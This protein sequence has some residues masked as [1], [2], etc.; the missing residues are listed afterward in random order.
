[1]KTKYILSFISVFILATLLYALSQGGHIL[2]WQETSVADFFDNERHNLIIKN[3]S[4]GEVR[5]PDPI[6]KTANDHINNSIPRGTAYD[7]DGNYLRVWVVWDNIFAQK[8]T[9]SG[10]TLSPKIRVNDKQISNAFD[11][12][13]RSALLDNG[14]F[15]V[16]WTDQGSNDNTMYGQAFSALTIKGSANFIINEVENGSN[17]IPAVWAN[18]N[19]GNFWILYSRQYNG[20]YKILV[21]KR[22]IQGSQI[23]S[24]FVLNPDNPTNYEAEVS[25]TSGENGSFVVAWGGNNENTSTAADV[26]IRKF[27]AAG[28]PLTQAV[29]AIREGKSSYQGHPSVCKDDDGNYLAAWTD[30][31][32]NHST[33]S[34]SFNIYGQFFNPELKKLGI[35]FRI[36]TKKYSW[37]SEPDIRFRDD[38]FETSG[39]WRNDF[40]HSR[41][42]P[43]RSGICRNCLGRCRSGYDQPPFPNQE[44][45]R[46]KRSCTGRL[47]WAK[48]NR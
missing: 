11:T 13:F 47:D 22:D 28:Q 6:V 26:Y 9:A 10:D 19:D 40:H 37:N 23:D 17:H 3:N 24:S 27:S 44:R 4:G 14:S 36:N 33:T 5:L 45:Y 35:N 38:A 1:M 20:K 16:V 42:R 43:R 46:H 34:V 48:R 7:S 41:Y 31:R 32:D 25:V 12:K 8:F 18:N 30:A 2:T 15:C 29:K 21:Q 39:K